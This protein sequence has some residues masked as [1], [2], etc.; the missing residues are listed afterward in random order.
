MNNFSQT[1]LIDILTRITPY[2]EPAKS[3]L[4]A[5]KENSLSPTSY[6]HLLKLLN[7]AITN[8][9]SLHEKE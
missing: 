7:T 5:I 2:W 9:Q 4:S 8:V 1:I 6:S 3:D